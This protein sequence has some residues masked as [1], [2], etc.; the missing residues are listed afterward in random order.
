VGAHEV[1]EYAAHNQDGGWET[2]VSR[3]GELYPAGQ[4]A[5]DQQALGARMLRRRIIVVD[6]WTE[7]QLH[8]NA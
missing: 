6:D 5:R 8:E 2:H 3:P 1:I 7:V 4:W